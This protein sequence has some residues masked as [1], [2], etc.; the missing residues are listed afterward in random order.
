[1]VLVNIN[2]YQSF[3]TN[4]QTYSGFTEF[5]YGDFVS[6]NIGFTTIQSVSAES[7]VM[8]KLFGNITASS[9]TTIPLRLGMQVIGFKTGGHIM[10]GGYATLDS[11]SATAYRATSPATSIADWSRIGLTLQ[12]S[13]QDL[14]WQ[15]F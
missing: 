8:V 6:G 9:E 1:M 3:K 15:H 13:I 12:Y 5:Y 2:D 10:V 11:R 14:K 7:C 4:D